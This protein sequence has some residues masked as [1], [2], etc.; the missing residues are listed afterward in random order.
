MM[1]WRALTAR[2]PMVRSGNV[3]RLR[4]VPSSTGS[5]GALATAASMNSIWPGRPAGQVTLQPAATSRRSS[6]RS[7]Q[8]PVRSID[9]SEPVSMV[10][11]AG[12]PVA[13][14][15]IARSSVAT[16]S[17]VQRPVTLMARCPS[18]SSNRRCAA[19]DRRRR[20]ARW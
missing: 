13:A 20:Q 2:C 4:A 19:M 8:A 18:W 10:A 15:A 5:A 6:E 16:W 3:T 17:T 11:A 12:D 9:P 7:S 14:V 1:P